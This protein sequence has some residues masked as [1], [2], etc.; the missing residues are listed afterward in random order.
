M[1]FGYFLVGCG[2]ALLNAQINAFISRMQNPRVMGLAHASYGTYSPPAPSPLEFNYTMLGYHRNRRTDLPTRLHSVCTDRALVF[3]LPVSPGCD[4]DHA[5]GYGHLLQRQVRRRYLL[6]TL[7]VCEWPILI[8]K[9]VILAEMGVA[10]HDPHVT[11]TSQGDLGFGAVMKHKLLHIMAA[12]V[13]VYVGTEVT[14][15]GW[16]VTFLISERGGGAEAGY[17]SSGFFGG[18]SCPS[19]VPWCA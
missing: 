13:F 16:I 12:F 6:I 10:H 1:C 18:T 17:V 5:F 19:L 11:T 15:G 9:A 2:L 3:S 7:L 8:N 14:V 4:N